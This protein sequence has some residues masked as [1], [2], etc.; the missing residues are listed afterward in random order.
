LSTLP[1]YTTTGKVA[2]VFDQVERV[3]RKRCR[4]EHILHSPPAIAIDVDVLQELRRRGCLTVR[5]ELVESG[6]TLSAPLHRFFSDAVEIER[7]HGVQRALP[8]CRWRI[9]EPRQPALFE[10][11]A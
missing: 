5:V 11:V 8:L 9:E 4:A 7:G 2:G 10:E 1:V 6:R 3:F